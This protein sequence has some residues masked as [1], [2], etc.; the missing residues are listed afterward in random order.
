MPAAP[1]D[2]VAGPHVLGIPMV[3]PSGPGPPRHGT[4]ADEVHRESL[5]DLFALETLAI[6]LE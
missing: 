2:F 1:A 3:L 6:T 4:S 5:R